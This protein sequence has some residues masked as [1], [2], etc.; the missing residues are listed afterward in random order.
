MF[1]LELTDHER[2]ALTEAL[3]SFLSELRTEVSHTDRQAFRQ[4]LREREDVLKGVFA[5][6]AAS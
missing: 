3:Q 6:L 2:Q 1:R 5:R 4:Q